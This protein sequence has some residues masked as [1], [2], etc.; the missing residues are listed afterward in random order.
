MTAPALAECRRRLDAAAR[1]TG[2]V[3]GDTL[4]ALAALPASDLD[5]VL[6][7]FAA[8]HGAAALP[9]LTTLAS[10]RA[11]RELRR[12]ARRSLYRLAQRGIAAPRAAP[13]RPVVEREPE[14]ATRAWTSG[15]DGSGSQAVW[16]V[17][18]GGFGGAALCSVIL[19]DTAGILEVAGGDITKKR[20]ERELAALRASQTLPWVESEPARAV[21]LVREALARHAARGT[22]PPAAFERWQRAFDAAE[23]SAAPLPAPPPAAPDAVALERSAG[24]LE[25]PDFAGWF[26][27]PE[28]L[29]SDAVALLQTRESRLVV[30]DQIKAEREA[31]IVDAVIER[32]LGPEARGRWARRLEEM[33]RIL[34]A[35]ER[36]EAAA[37]A[38]AA[39]A[40][41]RDETQDP[42]R[43]PFVLG[44]TR[45]GLE[46]TGEVALG[47]VKLSEVSRRPGAAGA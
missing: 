18:E 33:A 9:A 23:T 17:F 10:E 47:R 31:A 36:P 19:N 22:S 46:V 2:Q 13:A 38:G 45:R 44:L 11:E 42:R 40:A 29:Q 7:E 32:E 20:L 27:D 39:A 5:G 35:T 25:L 3:D 26:L 43:H 34:A 14:R 8:D 28:A 37:W 6:R 30:S 12:A 15:V 21:A 24:L 4:T 16:I 41:L 1:E